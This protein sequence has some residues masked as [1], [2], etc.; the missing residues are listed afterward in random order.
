[1]AANTIQVNYDALEQIMREFERCAEDS[2]RMH[3]HLRASV[4]NLVPGGWEGEGSNIF[5]REMENVVLPGVDRLAKALYASQEVTARLVREFRQA[6]EE[7]ASLFKQDDGSAPIQAGA[8]IGG[9]VG[10]AAGAALA[11]ERGPDAG[12]G[13]ATAG[14]GEGPA[15]GASGAETG[16]AAGP[17]SGLSGG[18]L[19]GS[20]PGI[21]G[22]QIGGHTTQADYN[23]LQS[24]SVGAAKTLGAVKGYLSEWKFISGM[25]KGILTG[26]SL[27][28]S[29]LTDED[30]SR[31]AVRAVAGELGKWA[32]KE[33]LK[34]LLP[35]LIGGVSV[36]GAIF[37]VSD[38]L[39]VGLY[40]GSSYAASTGNTGLANGI[41]NVAKTI[42]L[43]GYLERG[44]EI[45]YD[46]VKSGLTQAG[47]WIGS[48][49]QDFLQH[50][51]S[52]SL[53]PGSLQPA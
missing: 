1:M 16:A 26:V 33:G 32:L 53:L 49:V 21:Q 38:V 8:V 27:G 19:S 4:E 40:L 15:G 30:I 44:A 2:A 45:A 12:S 52:G 39:Q 29:I 37:V 6:E 23:W 51:P 20:G 42:D 25:P 24:A 11:G 9:A 43:S 10:S 35:A 34:K 5:C 47:G 41:K 14:M 28:A 31:D 46:A 18:G 22:G 7:G 17:G 50:S 36:V 3:A 13:G 48:Q